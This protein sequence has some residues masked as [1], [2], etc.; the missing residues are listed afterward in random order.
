L[1]QVKSGDP[2][3]KCQKIGVGRVINGKNF[4]WSWKSM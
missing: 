3:E 2:A 1:K 4:I